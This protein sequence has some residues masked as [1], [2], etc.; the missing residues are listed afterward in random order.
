[1]LGQ[2]L[3]AR[4]TSLLDLLQKNHRELAKAMQHPLR[5][6]LA[7]S[8]LALPAVVETDYSY[9]CLESDE[10]DYQLSRVVSFRNPKGAA[11]LLEPHIAAH[12]DSVKLLVAMA[13]VEAL[14]E[15]KTHA[16]QLVKR[17]LQLAPTDIDATI[18]HANLLVVD[19]IITRNDGWRH[20]WR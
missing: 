5:N 2:Y 6:H 7:D 19:C 10:R 15:D 13:R 16:R 17:A 11:R 8:T 1:M 3:S 14:Q 18:T 12:P 20:N 4:D 9:R